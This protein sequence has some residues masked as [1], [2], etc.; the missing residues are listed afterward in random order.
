MFADIKKINIRHLWHMIR[1]ISG[2]DAYDRYL[3]HHAQFHATSVDVPAPLSR[4]A[5][6]K[7]WQES[8]WAGINRCC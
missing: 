3:M 8:K 7:L 2:D 6:F 1:R 4:K 5:F